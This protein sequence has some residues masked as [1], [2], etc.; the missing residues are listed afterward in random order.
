MQRSSKLRRWQEGT[1]SA[2]FDQGR[3]ARSGPSR[4]ARLPPPPVPLSARKWRLP[5]NT[6]PGSQPPL[7]CHS[8]AFG[9]AN[10]YTERNARSDAEVAPRPLAA[11]G[12]ER[13]RA[14]CSA[15]G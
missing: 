1:G 12:H 3:L 5:E 13:V 10:T 15:H 9:L 7:A 2:V 8:T 11:R 14:A 6:T 4:K